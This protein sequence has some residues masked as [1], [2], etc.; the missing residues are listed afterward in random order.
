MNRTVDT[1]AEWESL[2]RAVRLESVYNQRDL[3]EILLGDCP[4]VSEI[5]PAEQCSALIG[6]WLEDKDV[7]TE[8]SPE[9]WDTIIALAQ[10]EI[11]RRRMVGKRILTAAS[12]E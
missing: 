8:L 2:V 5:M 3:A 1:M 7:T 9:T 6:E 10:S 4:G 11:L 12:W